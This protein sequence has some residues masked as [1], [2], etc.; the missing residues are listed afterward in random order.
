MLKELEDRFLKLNH[1]NDLKIRKMQKYCYFQETILFLI[2]YFNGVMLATSF[3]LQVSII[4][5][6]LE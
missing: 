1:S 4:Q 6:F 3:P 5:F 2:N